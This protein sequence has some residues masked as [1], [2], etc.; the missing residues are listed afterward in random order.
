MAV[1]VGS[2]PGK[3]TGTRRDG[4]LGLGPTVQVVRDVAPFEGD[5]YKGMFVRVCLKACFG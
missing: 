3:P 4:S 2:G 5:V 1:A